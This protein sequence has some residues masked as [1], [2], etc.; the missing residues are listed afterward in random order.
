MAS[1]YK[2]M[3]CT[4]KIEPF[5]DFLLVTLTVD[6]LLVILKNVHIYLGI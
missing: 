4:E 3:W 6:N 1:Y 5:M 2:L